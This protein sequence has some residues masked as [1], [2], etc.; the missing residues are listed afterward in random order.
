MFTTNETAYCAL[1]KVSPS[2]A[3]ARGANAIKGHLIFKNVAYACFSALS[4]TLFFPVSLT[5]TAS[6]QVIA[7]LSPGRMDCQDGCRCPDGSLR[8]RDP[9]QPPRGQLSTCYSVQKIIT[10]DEVTSNAMTKI[11][12]LT[13]DLQNAKTD[14]A[15]K[16]DLLNNR[17]QKDESA[18]TKL[19]EAV[20]AN[21]LNEL[22]QL[23][24]RVAALEMKR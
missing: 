17:V 24:Q 11:T 10:L 6:A 13:H 1:Q 21:L 16:I 22:E 15:G 9:V 14:L 5:T 12:A 3:G 20:V 23:K 4:L 2:G 19:D 7:V 8:L 18:P